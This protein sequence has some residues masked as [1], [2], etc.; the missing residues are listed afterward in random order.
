M[1]QRTQG[2]YSGA[3][4]RALASVARSPLRP[5]LTRTLRRKLG[6]DA[7]GE[8][9][10]DELAPL[11]LELYPRPARTHHERAS[12]RLGPLLTSGWPHTVAS[13][14]RAY[15]EGGLDPERVVER[16]LEAARG[17][18]GLVPARG[19]L[20][21]EDRERALAAARESAARLAR[22]EP[23]SELEGIPIAVKEELDFEG[24]PTR[25]G[26]SWGPDTPAARDAV[27]LTHLRQ[28]GAVLL[29][30]TP[31]TEHGLSPFG[32][33][34]HRTMPRNAHDARRVAG[35]SSTGSAVAVAAGITPLA[36]G[37]DGGGSIRIPAALNGVFGIKPT[38]GRIPLGGLALQGGTS[39]AAIGPLGTS[40]HD[41][42][43]FLTTTA[44]PDASDPAS[45]RQPPLDAATLFGALEQGVRGLRIG[46]DEAEWAAAPGAVTQPA[47]AALAALV[48]D[49]AELVPLRIPLL[50]RAPA[51]GY[52]TL[53]VEILASLRE[54]FSEHLGELGPDLQLVLLAAAD[55]GAIELLTVQRVRAA[56]QREVSAALETVDVLAL[57]T[58]AGSAPRVTDREATLGF[59]DPVALDTLCRFSGLANLTG[60]PAATAP[61]GEDEAGLPLGLQIVG[62]AWD[63]P[64]VL[65]V[66]AH[67]ERTGIARVRRPA[68]AFDPD[69]QLPRG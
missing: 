39:L 69:G 66:L 57:P 13:Y 24:L 5:I 42:A 51:A 31:M 4:L 38:F 59:A 15:R 9:P 7:L 55:Y 30:Q 44:R 3:T 16:A 1:S 36:V 11:P 50:A 28:A 41:L 6:I 35:G 32:V 10:E 65:S 34:P 12:E 56:L 63:E 14:A 29:G 53:S 19:P 64:G 68:I 18:S 17:L 37:V 20:L 40:S 8:L 27:V 23:R 54:A 62:D 61:V 33:N 58:T 47:H 67:L 49:G 26:S 48:T 60:L 46:I 2:R 21:N 52:V 22:G 25:A 45:L 43:C